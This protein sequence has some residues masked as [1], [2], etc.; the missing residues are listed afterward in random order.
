MA[1]NPN[2]L[3]VVNPEADNLQKMLERTGDR[4][5][6]MLKRSPVDA[7]RFMAIA[8]SIAKSGDFGSETQVWNGQQVKV[9]GVTIADMGA[10]IMR[11][12]SLS[13]D[14]E[15]SLGQVFILPFA[16]GNAQNRRKRPQIVVGYKGYVE[17]AM[18]SG[19]YGQIAG[20]A[21]YD[22]ELDGNEPYGFEYYR[23]NEIVFRHKR[24]PRKDF[25]EEKLGGAYAFATDAKRPE[26]VTAV[27]FVPTW[28]IEKNHRGRSASAANKK[29]PWNSDTARMYAKTA[30]RVLAP[31]IRQ[32][33]AL[34]RAMAVDEVHP[35][36]IIDIEPLEPRVTIPAAKPLLLTD[37]SDEEKL[38]ITPWLKSQK[39]HNPAQ[40]GQWA[41]KGDGK[42]LTKEQILA[43]AE[44]FNP[45]QPEPAA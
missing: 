13:L 25:S 4:I 11:V 21:V 36:E 17:L 7:G 5:A 32:T 31:S 1:T 12:A 16:E 2:G 33:P 45:K 41:L 39:V 24:D 34:S 26:L 38:A 18:R 42:G 30:V 15:P 40:F 9:Q 29:S 44:E 43:A 20:C 22:C 3:E 10:A 19:Y 35:D 14:P 28:Q 8:I 23:A 37:F 27:E 6:D